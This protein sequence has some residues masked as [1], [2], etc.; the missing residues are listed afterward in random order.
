MQVLDEEFWPN[1]IGCR[2]FIGHGLT[3]ASLPSNE[4]NNG[5][6][7]NGTG[8]NNSMDYLKVLLDKSKDHIICLQKTWLL[9]CNLNKLGSI[10]KDYCFTGKSGVESD[11]DII[12]RPKGGVAILWRRDTTQNVTVV[13]TL[14]KRTCALT[15]LYFFIVTNFYLYASRY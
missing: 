5:G 8:V 3:G 10:H 1:R 6:S 15:F 9:N 13:K 2:K 11:E 4:N 14:S 12:G 7:F